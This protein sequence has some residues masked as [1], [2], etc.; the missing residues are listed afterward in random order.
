MAVAQPM[1]IASRA[2]VS[3]P[4]PH[5]PH[6]HGPQMKCWLKP[7]ISYIYK[8]GS[9]SPPQSVGKMVYSRILIV[10]PAAKD[11]E[12]FIHTIMLTC[13]P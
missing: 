7:F 4:H 13:H 10:S 12:S 1:S 3:G 9:S 11:G 5:G 2:F 8:A 6:P